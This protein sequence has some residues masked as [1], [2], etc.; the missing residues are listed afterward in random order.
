MGVNATIQALTSAPM[1][2]Q[3]KARAIWTEARAD[4][5]SRLWQAAIGQSSDPGGV[6]SSASVRP[7]LDS[8]LATL[9]NQG[10]AVDRSG[11]AAP[12]AQPSEPPPTAAVDNA[13]NEPVALGANERFRGQIEQAGRRA[14]LP[15]SALASIINAE[16]GK[17][18]NGSWNLYSRNPRSSAAGLGQF[19]SGTWIGM[20][21]QK[22]TWLNA[23]ARRRG[24]LNESGQVTGASRASVLAMRYEAT[25]SI[26]TIADYSRSNLDRLQAAGV[27]IG[28]DVKSISRTA[29]MA[30]YMGP[31]DAIRFLK[32]NLSDGRARVLL[33]AQVGAGDAMRRIA[34]AGSASQAHGQWLMAH[35]DRNV[36]VPRVG[37]ADTV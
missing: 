14:K 36:R 20:A 24:L 6:A 23:E 35:I 30:H 5:A 19:L 10:S 9:A 13:A 2:N 25:A 16:A 15:P 34:S 31:G 1:S 12:S 26:E 28:N 4:M 7:G 3:A 11:I 32:G 18:R 21:E 27:T 33:A 37:K 8:L 29:Y 17:L 22:G